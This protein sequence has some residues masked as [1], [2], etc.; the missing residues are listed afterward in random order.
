MDEERILDQ[1]R[2]AISRQGLDADTMRVERAF[3]LAAAAHAGQT[4]S[5]GAPY[6]T[7][8]VGVARILL[9]EWDGRDA[10][11]VMAALLHDACEDSDL[12]LDALEAELGPRVR[13]LVDHLT[14]PVFGGEEDKVARDQ[15]YW[16]RLAS[17]PAEA[18]LV[19]A[20]DRIDNLRDVVKALWPEE[21]KRRYAEEAR[22]KL[23]P[24][25]R[26]RCPERVAA[27]LAETI[28]DVERRLERGE[29]D[30]PDVGPNQEA[31]AVVDEDPV[32]RRSEHLSLFHREGLYF[33]YHD[34]VGD[35]LQ[36]HEKLLPF[37]DFFVQPRRESE[38]RE[39]FKADFL[40]GDF[41]SLFETLRQH[42]CLL[43]ADEDDAG[44]TRGWYPIHG[45]WILSYRAP[46]GRTTVC[47]K[48]RREDAV[49]VERLEPGLTRLWELCDGGR[50]VLE[51]AEQLANETGEDPEAVRGRVVQTVQ[52]WT[53][54]RRQLLKLLPQN[55][56]IYDMIGLPPYASSTMPW[57]LLRPGDAPVPEPAATVRDYHKLEITSA[58]EQFDLRETTVSHAL[59][60]PHP[61]LHGRPYGGQ[62]AQVLLEREA[63]PAQD[64]RDR[65]LFAEV[66]GG[67][68]FVARAFLDALA[69]RAPRLY[70]RLR[71]LLIDLSPALQR[72]QRER[73]AVHG[74]E[75]LR[76]LRGDAQALPLRDR[77][78]DFLVSNEMIA[79]LEVAKVTREDLERDEGGGP[80]V[81][82]IRRYDLRCDDAPGEF[83]V[84]VGA[85][86]LVEE[87][88]RV[89]R[90]GGTAF[91]TE[92][93]S[94]TRYPELSTH[95]DHAEF[96]IH[97][98]HLKRAAEALG[99][100][101]SLEVLPS[102]LAMQTRVPVLQTTQAFFETFRAFMAGF[103]VKLEKIAYT[104]EML[105]DLAGEAVD[106]DRLDGLKFAPIGQR[107][108]GLKPPEFKVLLLRKPRAEGRSVQRVSVDL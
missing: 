94:H 14:K 78:V 104:R 2:D 36:M 71:Y 69:L 19:K 13:A 56:T 46:D 21:K 3:R 77:S 90:P 7:H 107:L 85:I 17:G 15:V 83:Y 18:V 6:L 55:R 43:G 48:D 30:L 72:A 76:Y 93:G 33:I 24:L 89:L 54:S 82:A 44:I 63:L 1:L 60:V 96:S 5:H 103:G 74:R 68:G 23:L 99:F 45:P 61:A 22:A 41:D 25:A 26:E 27:Q 59:R 50:T 91:I 70:N 53:H 39:V 42:L 10:E 35:I 4:R 98:G 57:A 31:A 64:G 9:D 67:T 84:N 62:L 52:A 38:A 11:L 51:V 34:L 88:A 97:Y 75:K 102:F 100:E 65:L 32:L 106:V 105:A 73:T 86:R 20:A 29:G 87:C 40:P 101:A 8:P 66:G 47:Y 92:Y 28:A 12:T 16:E 108:L 81:D 58:E 79:D 37:L 49:V 80:G 95:L